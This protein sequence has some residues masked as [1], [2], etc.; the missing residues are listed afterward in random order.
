MSA[1]PQVISRFTME[2]AARR[3]APRAAVQARRAA[4]ARPSST[5]VKQGVHTD[6]ETRRHWLAAPR[7][8][9]NEGARTV[10]AVHDT[11]AAAEEHQL[12]AQHLHAHGLGAHL[13]RDACARARF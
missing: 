4:R 9:E 2:A 6:D 12:L 1:R 8:A 5:T 13:L 11:V 3:A 7:D 10:Q